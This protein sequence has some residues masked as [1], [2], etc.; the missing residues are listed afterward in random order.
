MTK[1]LKNDLKLGNAFYQKN[2]SDVEIYV[3]YDLILDEDSSVSTILISNMEIKMQVEKFW[4][5]LL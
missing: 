4:G 3:A 2:W 1:I 5:R